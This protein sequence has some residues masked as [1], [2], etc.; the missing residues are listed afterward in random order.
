MY[1]QRKQQV[2][3]MSNYSVYFNDGKDDFVIECSAITVEELITDLKTNNWDLD[4]IV[5]IV[6]EKTIEPNPFG[7]YFKW[8]RWYRKENNASLSEAAKQHKSRLI[9]LENDP[10]NFEP[11]A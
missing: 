11:F 5:R 10:E 4:K 8:I 9:I 7:D 2:N 1:F 6:R 3:I